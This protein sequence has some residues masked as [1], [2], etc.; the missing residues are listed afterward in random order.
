MLSTSDQD[1]GQVAREFARQGVEATYFV[2]TATGLSK[3]II[4]ATSTVRRFL[5]LHGIHDF[6][7]QSQ[8]PNNKVLIDVDVIFTDRVERRAMSVYRPETKTGD[9]RFWIKGLRSYA[10]S[11]N[12]VA[13]FLTRERSLAIV[14]CSDVDVWASRLNPES[15][16]S[17]YLDRRRSSDAAEELLARLRT[18]CREG[19]IQSLREGSTGIGYTLET[20]LG[21]MA[22]SSKSPDFRGIEIKSGRRTADTRTSLFSKTPNWKISSLKNGGQILTHYGYDDPVTQRRQLYCSVAA[23]PNSQQLFHD[24]TADE[25]LV[26][27]LRMPQIAVVAWQLE[28]L[29]KTL[30]AKHRETFWVKA[31]HRRNGHGREEFHFSQAIHTKAALA[32][33]LGLLIDTGKVEMDLTLSR[34]PNGGTRDHGYLFKLWPQDL[35]LLFP[36]PATYD[37]AA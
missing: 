6:A 32:S 16:L 18:I 20:R 21:I 19:Y 1:I 23:K 30:A 12:L 7:K 17:E 2:P 35:E 4:D 5:L 13:I 29:E 26:E 24:V 31:E 10:Q 34:K 8:G 11:G 3:S 22:N 9:P 37:L 25:S 27:M 14:N 33:N 36:P 28:V 15:A